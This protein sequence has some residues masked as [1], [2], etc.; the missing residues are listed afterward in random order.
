M[1]APLPPHFQQLLLL[2]SLILA[3]L[4]WVGWTLQEVLVNCLVTCFFSFFCCPKQCKRH[5]KIISLFLSPSLFIYSLLLY[6]SFTPSFHLLL[7]G[8]LYEIQFIFFVYPDQ[9]LP[10]LKTS[11]VFSICFYFLCK[12][13]WFPFHLWYSS[14][15]PFYLHIIDILSGRLLNEWWVMSEDVASNNVCWSRCFLVAE[16]EVEWF[17][18]V[19]GLHSL[20]T[21]LYDQIICLSDFMDSC[22]KW[23]VTYVGISL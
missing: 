6:P 7:F 4:S 20:H 12:W 14:D 10:F 8:I 18:Q 11:S 9:K 2:V 3:V 1:C 15:L 17:V 22:L 21:I 13:L 19:I 5:F 23:S 16:L